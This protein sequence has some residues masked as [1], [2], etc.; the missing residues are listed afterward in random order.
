MCKTV[1]LLLI[2]LLS[3]SPFVFADEESFVLHDKCI[4]NLFIPAKEYFAGTDICV[5]RDA[6]GI[7][8]RFK[9]ENPEEEY[10]KLNCYTKDKL[11][12]IVHFLSEI[13]NTVI[14][15]VHTGNF[16]KQ[17]TKE[18]KNWEISTI[19]ANNIEQF[20][21]NS[22]NNM[23]KNR[24]SSVGFGEFLPVVPPDNTGCDNQNRVDII[25]LCAV[26]KD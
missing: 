4:T 20:L 11:L 6:H 16:A 25:I 22:S 26:V 13:K 1:K 7:I 24:V 8:L 3:F 10:K 18:L 2:I 15:R 5:L 17:T 19:I 14:V 21:Y 23:D 12:K 9:I